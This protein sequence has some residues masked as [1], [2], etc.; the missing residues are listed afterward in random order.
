MPRFDEIGSPAE[1]SAS[2]TSTAS[3]LIIE[4]TSKT[5]KTDAESDIT[6]QGDKNVSISQASSTSNSEEVIPT[7]NTEGT[8]STTTSNTEEILSTSTSSTEEVLATSK[9]STEEVLSTST[10][11]TKE[12]LSTSNTE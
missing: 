11:N 1:N 9:S 12:V 7:S 6:I 8:L 10:S 5:A 2:L 3:T 4:S